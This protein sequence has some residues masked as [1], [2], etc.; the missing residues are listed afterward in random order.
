MGGGALY[1]VRP[2]PPLFFCP[3]LKISLGN[4]H[5]KILDLSKLFISDAPMK[6]KF[7]KFIFTPSHAEHFEIWVRKSPIAERVKF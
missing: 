6:K 1:G 2:P 7:K 5:L 4:P 3:L